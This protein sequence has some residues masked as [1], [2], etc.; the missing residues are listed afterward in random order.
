MKIFARNHHDK[1]FGY[2]TFAENKEALLNRFGSDTL[3]YLKEL[4]NV[5]EEK[6]SCNEMVFDV[7]TGSYEYFLVIFRKDGESVCWVQIA[8]G[9]YGMRKFHNCQSDVKGVIDKHVITET[10]AFINMK[11]ADIYRKQLDICGIC[12]D[13]EI[14]ID[15]YED[16]KQHG[17]VTLSGTWEEIVDKFVTY[18][19]RMRYCNGSSWKFRNKDIYT[20][21]SMFISNYNGNYFLD[22]AV[23]RGCIID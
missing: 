2:Q 8:K 20:L 12:D 3:D 11:N 6:T 1:N 17:T 23:R 14:I 19:D 15:V 22:N 16:Y 5:V 4:G 10:K 18:N 21:Y 9:N 13:N 7:W